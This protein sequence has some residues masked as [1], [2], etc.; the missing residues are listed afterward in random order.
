LDIGLLR[1]P[2]R[3]PELSSM[4]VLNEKFVVCRHSSIPDH[5]RPRSLADFDGLPIIMYAP[6]KAHCF[7][8]S[9]D[10]PVRQ[11]P[12]LAAPGAGHVAQIHTI[13][14][15]VGAGHGYALVPEA[16][17]H[18]HPDNVVFS[19]LENA[20]PIVELRHA[21]S[22]RGQPRPGSAAA[23]DQPAPLDAR[24]PAGANRPRPDHRGRSMIRAHRS[25]AR[26]RLVPAGRPGASSPGKEIGMARRPRHDDHRVAGGCRRRQAVDP[27]SAA[28]TGA[29]PERTS[30]AASPVQVEAALAAADR[31]APFRSATAH[32]PTARASSMRWPRQSS[33]R[34]A[35]A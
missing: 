27:G 6:D 32:R 17:T 25:I 20:E 28:E 31:A 23:A 1:P 15:L 33:P 13:L 19:E 29:P 12:R 26:T 30:R 22:A 10:W 24:A 7:P 4:R 3:R 5:A 18:L 9:R 14:T 16:S 21:A 35:M 8:R 2:V 34:R 11:R